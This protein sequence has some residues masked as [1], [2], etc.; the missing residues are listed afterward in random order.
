M[1]SI[2]T[3]NTSA[4]SVT[5]FISALARNICDV[6]R[7]VLVWSVG[8]IVTVT[9]GESNPIYKWES[10]NTGRTVVQLVGF[11]VLISGNLLYNNLVKFGCL[12]RNDRGK[13]I[14]I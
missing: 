11:L 5:K 13:V 6:T 10:T 2:L 14:K 1:F 4:T 8:I 12:Q 9:V 3:Y 7:T